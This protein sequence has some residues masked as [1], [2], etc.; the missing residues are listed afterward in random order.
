MKDQFRSQTASFLIGD[1]SVVAEIERSGNWEAVLRLCVAWN[2]A[3]LFCK[4]VE[5]SGAALPA[6][7]AAWTNKLSM[8]ALLQTGKSLK[9]GLDSLAL[10]EERSIPCAGFKGLA[11]IAY[12]YGTESGERGLRD[13]D[14]LVPAAEAKPAVEAL[15][16][17]GYRLSIEAPVER[18]MDFVRRSPGSAGN[19]AISLF[20]E[21]GGG[22][23]V[24]WRLGSASRLPLLEEAQKAKIL[25]RAVPVVSPR[26]SIVLAAHHALR[27]N[28][29]AD[30]MFRD[31]LD[32]DSWRARVEETLDGADLLELA[33]GANLTV[34]LLALEQIAALSRGGA[35]GWLAPVGKAEDCRKAEDLAKLYFHQLQFGPVNADLVH[36]ASPFAFLRTGVAAVT[37]WKHFRN[38]MEQMDA[39]HGAPET[40]GQRLRRFAR[41]A[42]Q[43][44]VRR[45]GQLR[46]LATMKR[47]LT[48]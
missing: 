10:L 22:V 4:R 36:L 27:N 6:S 26:H 14:I 39:S 33:S 30:K 46:T 5:E 18:Y 23:D 44:P 41:A 25:N 11:S 8:A 2:M 7:C 43:F 42:P 37:G 24:H 19:E 45:W 12:L 3:P 48:S 20:N 21:K 17:H 9:S 47:Q 1:R 16:A 13:V 32:F 31:V 34:A 40:L 29:D 28:F 38:T 35:A 15:L